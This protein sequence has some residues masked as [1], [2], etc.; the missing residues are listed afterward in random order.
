MW[1]L[2]RAAKCQVLQL[3]I[4]CTS[5]RSHGLCQEAIKAKQYCRPCGIRHSL[6]FAFAENAMT[7]P[8]RG[9]MLVQSKGTH[10]VP[11]RIAR[12][13]CTQVHQRFRGN[14]TNVKRPSRFLE[15]TKLALGGQS[16]GFFDRRLLRAAEC[17]DGFGASRCRYFLT[18]PQLHQWYA[19]VAKQDSNN[20]AWKNVPGQ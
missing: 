18:L 20:S 8:H 19:R 3:Q 2:R 15:G 4:S 7:L 1:R 11:G 14:A 10:L 9:G 17:V 12:S 5:P 16:S 6:P 13:S